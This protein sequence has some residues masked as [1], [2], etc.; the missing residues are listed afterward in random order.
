MK[1]VLL[2]LTFLI[3][4]A[5]PLQAQT[6]ICDSTKLSKAQV[7]SHVDELKRLVE[8]KSGRHTIILPIPWK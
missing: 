3:I 7:L 4:G 6:P 5:I 2:L 1:H 8:E